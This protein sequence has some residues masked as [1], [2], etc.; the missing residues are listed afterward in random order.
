MWVYMQTM[1]LR[2]Q[3]KCGD[4]KTRINQLNEKRSLIP[5]G[6]RVPIQK[7][8]FCSCVLGLSE[9]P[10]CRERPETAICFIEQ[11]GRL[12]CLATG[13]AASQSFL[14]TSPRCSQNR[15][16]SSL[17][18]YDC[19]HRWLH[20]TLHHITLFSS[21]MAQDSDS[22]FLYAELLGFCF[23]QYYLNST[24]SICYSGQIF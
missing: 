13:L 21:I 9:L 14:S 17:Y 8:N 1:E 19:T 16:R 7:K 10:K 11:V 18:S 15:P 4:E 20:N 23:L 3:W 5:W 2:H 24:L 6:L 22:V 12:T